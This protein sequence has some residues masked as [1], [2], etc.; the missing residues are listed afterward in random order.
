MSGRR[1]AFEALKGHSYR[2]LL[3]AHAL[4]RRDDGAYVFVEVQFAWNAWKDAHER[5]AQ[6]A[7]QHVSHPDDPDNSVWQSAYS[8]VAGEIADAIAKD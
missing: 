7:R 2:T 1:A 8:H 4:A 5:C 6:L 3:G